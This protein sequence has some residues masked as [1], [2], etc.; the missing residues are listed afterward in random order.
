MK[1]LALNFE[2]RTLEWIEPDPPEFYA[3]RDVLYRVHEVGVCGTDRALASFRLGA[4]PADETKLVLGHEALGQV[5]EVGSGVKSLNR[6]DWVAPTV[7]R[8]CQPPCTSC[9]RGR[10]DLCISGKYTERGILR[11][12]GYFTE[13][14]VDAEEDLVRVPLKLVDFGVLI[15]PLSVAEKAILRALAVHEGEPRSALVLGLG[16]IG[17]LTAM[18]LKARG[19]AVRVHSLEPEDHPRVAILRLQ[20]IPYEGALKG[21]ADIVIEAAGSTEAALSA[22]QNMPPLGV[23]VVLGAPDGAGPVPFLRMI[24]NNQTIVGS[25]NADGES[26]RAAVEDL[27]RF[28]RRALAALITRARFSDLEKSLIGPPMVAPKVVHVL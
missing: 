2:A 11:L 15:E 3:N 16:P 24:I 25:V 20:D 13:R 19:Y 1:A 7:R 9:A 26:F 5:I 22:L 4:P 18:A 23:M 8:A 17:M 27:A 14:A 28:D 10:R 21:S 6:G 12:H